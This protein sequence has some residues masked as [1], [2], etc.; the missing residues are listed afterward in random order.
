M[1]IFDQEHTKNENS[2]N[3]YAGEDFD[4]HREI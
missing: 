1:K 2:D 4:N 3:D